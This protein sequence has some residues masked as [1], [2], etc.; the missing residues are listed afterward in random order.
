MHAA[1]IRGSIA[2]AKALTLVGILTREEETKIVEGLTAVGREWENGQ[3]NFITFFFLMTDLFLTPA[4]S[5]RF[6]RTMRTFTPRT[7]AA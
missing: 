4:R 5:F 1:D 7:S 6:S 2:Y 3:V